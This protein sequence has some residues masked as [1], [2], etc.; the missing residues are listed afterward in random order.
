MEI[1]ETE[2]RERKSYHGDTWARFRCFCGNEKWIKLARLKE[3]RIKSCGCA[4]YHRLPGVSRTPE[5][6]SWEKMLERCCNPRHRNFKNYGGRGIVVCDRW[7]T[8]FQNFYSD[9]GPSDGMTIERKDV[10]G[11]YEPNN[12]KWIPLKEQARN[13]RDT[14]HVKMYGR[15]QLLVDWAKELR[16]NYG[17]LRYRLGF[18]D[19]APRKRSMMH[20]IEREEVNDGTITR[21]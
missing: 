12:C 17:V 10:N 13:R 14:I 15:N 19:R 7:A 20:L 21:V 5:Y 16:I 8:S 18:A 1:L 9:M 2:W 11:N 6:R 3:G 4:R